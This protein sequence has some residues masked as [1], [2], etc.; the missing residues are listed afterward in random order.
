MVQTPSQ[1]LMHH[2]INLL[3]PLFLLSLTTQVQ[4]EV[5]K[6]RDA[7]GG[8]HFTD[9]P[10]AGKGYELIWQKALIAPKAVVPTLARSTLSPPS[11]RTTA[12]SLSPQFQP[13]WSSDKTKS[14]RQ[15]YGPLIEAAAKK[16]HLRPELL[17]AVVMVESNYNPN[18]ISD[19]GAQG[20]MQLIP[21]TASR[22]GVTDSLDPRQ[23]LSGGA[24]YLRDLLEMFNFNLN[25]ALAA[26]NA[27]ENAVIRHD[28]RI[29]PYEETQ[30]YVKRVLGYYAENR[31]MAAIDGQTASR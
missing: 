1:D 21:A 3:P 19:A 7:Q 25:L 23:N 14:N 8:I 20:L 27:G 28:N 13:S 16:V 9:A 22:Y 2:L 11:S 10:V 5:Y 17:H 30:N 18:A 29:P 15:L 4:A 31:I 24:A 6:Y 12:P 26:Y